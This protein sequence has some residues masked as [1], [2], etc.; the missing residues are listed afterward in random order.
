[1]TS[2]HGSDGNI[3]GS[4]ASNEGFPLDE[5]SNDADGDHQI[6]ALHEEGILSHQLN[7]T[8]NH[9]LLYEPDL[10]SSSQGKSSTP[11]SSS[12]ASTSSSSSNEKTNI[13]QNQPALPKSDFANHVHSDLSNG[14]K[15]N[16]NANNNHQQTN[17]SSSPSEEENENGGMMSEGNGTK[18]IK[19]LWEVIGRD[20]WL[21]GY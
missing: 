20:S 17:N 3:G 16:G 4:S 9:L 11:T 15:R 5:N 13:R 8:T 2:N 7:D 6:T 19:E 1:M 10:Q 21:D 18:V 14:N 12:F